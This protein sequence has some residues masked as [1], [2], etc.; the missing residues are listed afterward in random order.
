MF[1]VSFRGSKSPQPP[2]FFPR[3]SASFRGKKNI[4]Q[5]PTADANGSPTPAYSPENWELLVKSYKVVMATR[6]GQLPVAHSTGISP[7]FM[8]EQ[9]ALTFLY[10]SLTRLNGEQIGR[11][12]V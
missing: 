6:R 1:S 3:P 12:H 5:R 4:T 7:R 9:P 2:V 8:A 11:A 10:E